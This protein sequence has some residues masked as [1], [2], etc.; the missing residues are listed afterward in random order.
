LR[1]ILFIISI[2]FVA[3]T[4]VHTHELRKIERSFYYWKSV[5][6]LSDTEQQALKTLQVKTMYIKFFDVAWDNTSNAPTPIAQL[7][8]A[9]DGFLQQSNL[10]IIPTIFITNESIAKIDS[11]KTTALAADMFKLTK[12]ILI[13]NKLKIISEIQIDC[14]WTAKTKDN[15]FALLNK[16]QSMDTSIIFSS[17][18]RLHQIKFAGTTGVPAIQRGMLMCYNMG[19]LANEK[20]NNSILEIAELKKYIGNLK[21]YPLPLDV[22]LPL[23]NWKVHFRNGVFKGLIQD[24]PTST[25]TTNM[26]KKEA[27]KF[28]ALQ[29]TLWQ[30][31]DFK[32]GDIIRDEQSNY[33]AVLSAASLISAE[34]S[35]KNIRVSL[36]HLDTL[37]L[38]KFT[39]HEMENIFNEL[40]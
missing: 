23:F 3:C 19:N 8:I 33:K 22:A 27:N 2:S 6:K 7:R 31:Y 4:S 11:T 10:N 14:D 34:I 1:S 28:I 37:T 39:T 26:F 9:D 25:F 36:Y 15:Y 16:L 5:F 18:I 12:Q 32:K 35:N 17:T 20:T 13:A 30:G 38:N 29:D 21:N 40:L 24:L